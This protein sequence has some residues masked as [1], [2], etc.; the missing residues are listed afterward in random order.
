MNSD[1]EGQKNSSVGMPRLPS[2]SSERASL[3]GS[4]FL[5]RQVRNGN[6]QTAGPLEFQGRSWTNVRNGEHFGVSTALSPQLRGHQPSGLTVA[7]HILRAYRA[8][9]SGQ[10]LLVSAGSCLFSQLTRHTSHDA[11]PHRHTSSHI[12]AGNSG[13][14][15]PH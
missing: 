1:S 4:Q 2:P 9:D 14:P 13:Q 15:R 5:Y 8:H 11:L 10:C 7:I 3:S 6:T 12:P